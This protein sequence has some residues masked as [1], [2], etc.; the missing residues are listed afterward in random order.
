MDLNLFTQEKRK[1]NAARND[2]VAAQIKEC[3]S[4]ALVRGDFP[5]L[6]GHESASY[7]KSLITITYVKLSNDLRNATVFFTTLSDHNEALQFFELQTHFFKNLI[8]KKLKL[9][10]IP[11][12]IFKIDDT[13]DYYDKIDQILNNCN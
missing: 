2:K 12:L 5:I 1:T 13:F 9:R 3:F 11:N 8:A 4:M 7:M 6:P 10:F